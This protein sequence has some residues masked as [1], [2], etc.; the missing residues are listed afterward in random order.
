MDYDISYFEKMLRIN[1]PTAK[2][3][4][5]IRWAWIEE[6]GANTILDYGSGIGFFRAFKNNGAK[7]DTYDIGPYCQ[8]GITLTRYDLITMWDVLEHLEN[9]DIARQVLLMTRF[10]AGA[11]PILPPGKRLEDWKHFKPKEHLRWFEDGDL[12]EF[13]AEEGFEL[14]KKGAPECPPREDIQSF[15]YRR[16]KDHDRFNRGIRA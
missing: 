3:I 1:A 4:N 6:V 14:V 9:L 8:T 7:V 2:E 13:M 12:E 11:V 15:L 16:R 5:A 10:F